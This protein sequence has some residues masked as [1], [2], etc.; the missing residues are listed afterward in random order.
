VNLCVF[1]TRF[2]PDA[3]N[4]VFPD[5]QTALRDVKDGMTLFCGGFGLAGTPE[6]L[7][8]RCAISA[9]ELTFVSNNAGTGAQRARPPAQDRAGEEMISS[10]VA[11][12]PF[13]RSSCSRDRSKSS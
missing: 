12:T 11:R 8:W 10:Y 3:L 1:S 7:I 5:A 6:E 2:S 9:A 13:S 4:K